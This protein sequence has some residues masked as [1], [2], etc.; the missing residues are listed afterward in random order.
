M[1][2]SQNSF[3]K[4]QKEKL[5]AQKKKE[6]QARKEERKANAQGGGLDNMMAYVDSYGNISDTP[7]DEETSKQENEEFEIQ[8][9]VPKSEDNTKVERRGKVDF[10]D[11]QKGFGFIIQ[12]GSQEKF[13]VHE[14]N[15]IDPLREGAKVA[16]KI[17]KGLKG[18]D[19]I[20]VKSL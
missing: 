13:F 6:K 16:F 19:A 15:A 9:S 11:A 12:D 14:S 10:F 4:K 2:R 7:I 1:G 20:E 5:K 18:M 17:Q 8:V 3:L